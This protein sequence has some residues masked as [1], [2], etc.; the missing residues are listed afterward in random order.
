[1]RR[2]AGNPLSMTL[3]IVLRC[4]MAS[5]PTLLYMVYVIHFKSLCISNVWQK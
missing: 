2:E 5:A 1:M 4:T 3:N